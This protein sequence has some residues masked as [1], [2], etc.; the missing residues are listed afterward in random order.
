MRRSDFHFDLPEHLIAQRPAPERT[1]SRLMTVPLDGPATIGA[2][3]AITEAFRGDEVLVLNDTRV[4]PARVHGQKATGGAVEVLVTEPRGA[5]GQGLRVAALLRGKRLRPGVEL[6]LPDCTATIVER[7]EDGS[8]LVDLHDVPPTPDA[9]WAWLD[10]VGSIPLPPYIDRTADADDKARY[11]TVVARAPGAVAAP[12]AGL[13]FS[14]ALLDTLRGRGV[15]VHTVTLHVGPGTFLPV[16]ADDLSQ[17]VMHSEWMAVPPETADAV[18]SGAPVVA[19]GT[20][21]VRALESWVRAPDA[22]QTDLFITPGFDYRVVDGLLTNFHL[23]ESTLL[24]LVSAFAGTERVLAAYHAAVAAE[25]RFYSYG[26]AML[27]RRPGGRWDR[28]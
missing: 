15:R 26:D 12:T 24:M 18:T 27:L 25:M 16:R 5:G 14:D 22:R 17:H 1:A 23:P 6:A 10:A 28:P 8:V 13:H 21:V 7:L 9:L 3:A 4:V 11:Q 20:T 19:V 2:F